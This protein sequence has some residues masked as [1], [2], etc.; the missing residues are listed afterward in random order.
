M[1]AMGRDFYK[2][3]GVER[4]ATAED[5]KKAYKKLAMK[6]HPDKAKDETTKAKNEEKFKEVAE[7]YATLSDKEKKALYDKYGEEGLKAGESGGPSTHFGNAHT[8]YSYSNI[9]PHELFNGVFGPN[10]NIFSDGLFED[11]DFT[12]SAANN[13]TMFEHHPFGQSFGMGGNSFF[14]MNNGVQH[15]QSLKRRRKEPV[16][17]DLKLSL[18]EIYS[19][20]QKK[21]KITRQRLREGIRRSESKVLEIN[22]KPGWKAGTK[23]TFQG[24]GDEDEQHAAGDIIFKI[25]EKTHPVFKRDGNDLVY[26]HK[27]PLRDALCGGTFFIPTIDGSRFTLKLEEEVISP[28]TLRRISGHGM[29]ISKSPHQRG[30]LI[31]NFDIVFPSKLSQAA[32]RQIQ[33]IIPGS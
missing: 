5:I 4:S 15:G 23:V 14:T 13:R 27:L 31:V 22:V 9:D 10:F 12:T 3:L 6:Y 17:Y 33:D 24:D 30:D 19:G 2:I 20:C 32:K 8:A 11:M 21:M 29:P 7:A 16:E 1:V 26:T 28:K 18:E 25:S